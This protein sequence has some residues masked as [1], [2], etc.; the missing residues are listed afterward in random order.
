[1]RSLTPFGAWFAVG[2]GL[3][4]SIGCGADGARPDEAT[5]LVV[6]ASAA[7]LASAAPDASYEELIAEA[8]AHARAGRIAAA[9]DAYTRA[10]ELNADRV[11]A[12]YG[13]GFVYATRCRSDGKECDGCDREMSFV[14]AHGGY[15]LARHTRGLCKQLERKHTE[16][17]ADFDAVL[18]DEGDNPD[19][20]HARGL[21]LLALQRLDEG[22]KDL[23]VAR[24]AGVEIDSAANAQCPALGPASACTDED[25]GGWGGDAQCAPIS[26]LVLPGAH[27]ECTSNSDCVRVGSDCAPHAVS[28]SSK[29]TYGRIPPPCADPKA[30]QC[31]PRPKVACDR[32]C[33][34]VR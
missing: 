13:M 12:H 7:T 34:V 15:R 1:M 19:V 33:C 21:S 3:L 24:A 17:V 23:E 29:A 4:S 20:R 2:C 25:W 8:E 18:A 27:R 5:T 31:A 32:G 22:C 16:A 26:R 28:I 30:G 9:A 6:S 11:E 10:I 14:L